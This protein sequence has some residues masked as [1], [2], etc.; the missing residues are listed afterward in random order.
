MV[1]VPPAG[2]VA[3]DARP[4]CAG[5]RTSGRLTL[6][7]QPASDMYGPASMEEPSMVAI[8]LSNSSV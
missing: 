1:A 2:D 5:R 7:R 8:M 4:A 6:P 3:I